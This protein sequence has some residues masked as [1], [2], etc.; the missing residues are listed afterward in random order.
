MFGELHAVR[1]LP[2]SALIWSLV[3]VLIFST[4]LWGPQ[5]KAWAL[6]QESLAQGIACPRPQELLGE[7]KSGWTPTGSGQ[8]WHLLSLGSLTLK[9]LLWAQFKGTRLDC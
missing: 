6:L 3:S 4:S 8:R 1:S 2:L 5:Q 7:D 9:A